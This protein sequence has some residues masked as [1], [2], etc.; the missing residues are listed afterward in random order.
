[1]IRRA[2]SGGATSICLALATLGLASSEA[3]GPPNKSNVPTETIQSVR[4]L[5]MEP[6]SVNADALKTAAN[7]IA[8][9]VQQDKLIPTR[10]MIFADHP[11]VKEA[12]AD[13]TIQITATIKDEPATILVPL[14]HKGNRIILKTIFQGKDNYALYSLPDDSGVDLRALLKPGGG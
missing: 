12:M 5:N 7:Q 11:I 3:G 9:F 6:D 14:S 1:V 10:V 2:V 8:A 13:K 4:V